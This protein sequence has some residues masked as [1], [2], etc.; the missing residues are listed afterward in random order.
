M[1]VC[2]IIRSIRKQDSLFSAVDGFSQPLI[3]PIVA[4]L[5]SNFVQDRRS[6]VIITVITHHYEVHLTS[7]QINGW[8][9]SFLPCVLRGPP[10]P[11][12]YPFNVPLET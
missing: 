12:R 3:F 1:V 2:V 10:K 8:F 6:F 9:L 4:E 11:H 7:Q 5:M